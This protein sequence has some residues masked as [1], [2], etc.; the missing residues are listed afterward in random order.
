M[1][2]PTSLRPSSGKVDVL[3]AS[4]GTGGTITGISRA[5]KREHNPKCIVVGIDP[6]GCSGTLLASKSL[7][8]VTERKHPR[9]S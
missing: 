7:T 1:T 6:V 8:F 5:L 4:A 2:P 9:L 3:V